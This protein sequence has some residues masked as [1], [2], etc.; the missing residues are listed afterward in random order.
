MSIRDGSSLTEDNW[1]KR[2]EMK[3][4]LP[5][6]GM[7]PRNQDVDHERRDEFLMIQARRIHAETK[8]EYGALTLEELMDGK[9][10]GA[11]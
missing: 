9:P 6:I 8:G 1:A 4:I 5:T 11:R 2:Q 3:L 10:W 7:E